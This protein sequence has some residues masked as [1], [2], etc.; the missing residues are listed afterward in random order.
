MAQGNGFIMSDDPSGSKGPLPKIDFSSFIL[1]LYSS[2]LVQLGKVED[3]TT[4]KKTLNLDLAKHTINMIAMI[5]EK[6]RGNLTDDEKNLLKAL[7]SEIRI[8]FVEAKA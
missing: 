2:G 7:L 8:A 6:T 5:E 4:G 1:S 3:P